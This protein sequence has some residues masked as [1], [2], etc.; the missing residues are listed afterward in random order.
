MKSNRFAVLGV[1]IKIYRS[2]SCQA[3]LSKRYYDRA[4][5]GTEVNAR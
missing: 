4:T 5:P 1:K 3:V 2:T